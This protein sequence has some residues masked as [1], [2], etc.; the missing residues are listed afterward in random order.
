MSR[1]PDGW[2]KSWLQ[3][4]RD[5]GRKGLTVEKIGNRHYVYW[6]STKWVSETK[7]RKKLTEYLGVLEPPG[8]LIIS[9]EIDVEKMDKRAI[10]AASID[11]E[12]YRK[13]PDEIIDYRIKGPML[14]LKRACEDF[15]PNLKVCFPVV[16]DDLLMLAMARLSGRG[17][18]CQAGDWFDRQDN[19]MGLQV[20]KTP[21]LL[22]KALVVAGG[23]IEAQDKFYESL[24]SPG[25]KIAVDMSVCF[26]K[27]KAYFIKKGYNRFRLS[28]GQFNVALICG[29]E[30]KMPQSLKTV[31]GNVKESC[32]IDILDEMDIG[33]DCI[34]VMDRGYFSEE[35]MND[36]HTKG[37]KFLIPVRRNSDLYDT[38]KIDVHKGFKFRGD[39]V[40]YGVGEGYGFNAY[41][42]ENER[43]RN[44][45]LTEL[46]WEDTP[47]DDKKPCYVPKDDLT[48]LEGDPTKAGNM[49]LVTNINEDPKKLY[50]MFK[51]RLSVEECNDTA[52]NVLSADSTYLR[53]NFSIMGFNFVSFLALRMYMTIEAWIAEKE[54]TSKYSPS[55]I[56]FEYG[57]IVSV[58]TTNRVV[59]QATPTNIRRIEEELGLG[60][61]K[62]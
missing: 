28:C 6:A 19:L 8:N 35:I 36:L 45:E 2:A 34:L 9:N 4:K 59:G 16:C 24:A 49:I 57:S 54:L 48:V 41:R 23:S 38:V 20:H 32:I 30:D 42:F 22:S 51:M 43:Q 40:L 33:T 14:V 37:Y 50:T 61:V 62:P 58:T 13:R 3:S 27:G 47:T 44:T 21:D 39:S 56:L 5:E 10:D 18:L 7:T 15:Y 17:R 46:M 29:L 53:D 12:R 1:E 31:A 25:K 26:N 11:V 52:K 55:D 60:L